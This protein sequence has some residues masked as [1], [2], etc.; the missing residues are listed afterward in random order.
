MELTHDYLFLQTDVRPLHQKSLVAQMGVEPISSPYE[1][2]ELPVLFRTM[3]GPNGNRT[4]V[5]R[6][7][8]ERSNP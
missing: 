8:A 6:A 7:T 2:D 1:S 4:H 5:P 3:C